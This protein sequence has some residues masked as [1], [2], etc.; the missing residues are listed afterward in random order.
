MPDVNFNAVCCGKKD[1]DCLLTR[2]QSTGDWR[3]SNKKLKRS[4]QKKI[5]RLKAHRFI[6]A[7]GQRLVLCC[8]NLIVPL[9]VDKHLNFHFIRLNIN[10][11]Q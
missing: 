6:N 9:V 4:P 7:C 3:N 2:G 8:A 5:W 10:E 11:S 1:A